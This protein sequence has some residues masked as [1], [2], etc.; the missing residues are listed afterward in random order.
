MKRVRILAL[1]LLF[2]LSLLTGCKASDAGVASADTEATETTAAATGTVTE[3]PRESVEVTVPKE[4]L[5]AGEG[6]N[7]LTVGETGRIR[8]DY[9]G[10]LSSV[11]Y[12]TS[13]DR[14]PDYPELEGY[15]EAYFQEKALILVMETVTSGTVQVGIQGI[16]LDGETATVQLS[17]EN[18]GD[19][20]TAVMTTW[21]IWAEVEAGLDYTWTVG[22]PAVES[23]AE[24]S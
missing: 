19:V 23:Q 6:E 14:L 4:G 2:L 15:D 10:N 11:R 3:I 17:H 7:G 18:Q 12:I 9:T 21:L 1:C 20:G 24:R 13:A 5:S 8:V 22:N 16:D